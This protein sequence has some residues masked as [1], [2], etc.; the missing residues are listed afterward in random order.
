MANFSE[1]YGFGLGNFSIKTVFKKLKP[2]EYKPIICEGY[3]FVAIGKNENKE[4][5]FGMPTDN[6]NSVMWVNEYEMKNYYK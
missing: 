3:G 5:I 2:G 4:L 1:E 6:I